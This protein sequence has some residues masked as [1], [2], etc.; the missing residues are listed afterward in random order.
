MLEY[1][2]ESKPRKNLLT[3]CQ[4][5]FWVCAHAML[6]YNLVSMSSCK[7][8][9]INRL[10]WQTIDRGIS[11]AIKVRQA[12]GNSGKASPPPPNETAGYAT[13]M[14]SIIWSGMS[15][16]ICHTSCSSSICSELWAFIQRDAL[17][18][19]SPKALQSPSRVCR[20]L[21]LHASTLHALGSHCGT[22][23]RNLSWHGHRYCL[24]SWISA[25]LIKCAWITSWM[26]QESSWYPTDVG[27]L[28]EFHSILQLEAKTLEQSR[29]ATGIRADW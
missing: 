24:S 3:V 2:L 1:H 25:F 16:L 29:T 4:Q 14:Q 9:P 15:N 19:P 23:R 20:A 6:Q 8:G 10:S 17:P 28:F 11:I 26:L 21:H 12:Q 27:I 22:Y 7:A 13:A 18:A 5:S